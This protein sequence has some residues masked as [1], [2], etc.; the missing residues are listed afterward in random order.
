[1][2]LFKLKGK[3]C[4]CFSNK[5]SDIFRGGVFGWGVVLFF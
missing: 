1:M 4:F 5:I 3:F 2:F